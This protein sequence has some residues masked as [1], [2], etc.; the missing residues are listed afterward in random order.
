MLLSQIK[1]ISVDGVASVVEDCVLS[2]S[3][4]DKFSR[5]IAVLSN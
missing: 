5:H 3:N 1:S 2:I 4:V